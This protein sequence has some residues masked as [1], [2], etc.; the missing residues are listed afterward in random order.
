MGSAS[1]PGFKIEAWGCAS[2]CSPD[3]SGVQECSSPFLTLIK[4]I[5]HGGPVAQQTFTWSCMCQAKV[6]LM[7][8]E[9]I[10]SK[11]I[12]ENIA[13]SISLRGSVVAGVSSLRLWLGLLLAQSLSCGMNT[14]AASSASLSI[15]N[16]SLALY[17]VL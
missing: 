3:C 14:D 2:P 7:K 5:C 13:T 15:C 17:Y 16:H 11:K 10:K 8:G 4:G 1:V 12:F 6:M 9:K